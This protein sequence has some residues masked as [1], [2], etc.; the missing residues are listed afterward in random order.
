MGQ[1]DDQL[2]TFLEAQ[3]AH[4]VEQDGES[5]RDRENE[6]NLHDADDQGVGQGALEIA[7]AEDVDEML[8]T[9]PGALEDRHE[10]RVGGKHV[11]VFESQRDAV[12]RNQIEDGN[13]DQ[14][15]NQQQIHVVVPPE[16]GQKWFLVA[17]THARTLPSRKNDG[18]SRDTSIISSLLAAGWAGVY[19]N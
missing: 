11:V 12:H 9:G 5:D 8:Q 17:L 19:E 3:V 18:R 10:R 6:D 4:F 13:K 1:V 7:F 16:I 15:G 2:Q 14:G